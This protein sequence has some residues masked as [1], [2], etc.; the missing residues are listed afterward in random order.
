MTIGQEVV[1]ENDSMITLKDLL[2]PS[3][4]P[5]ANTIKRMFVIVKAMHE[6]AITAIRTK[7]PS[8]AA[9]VTARDNDVDRLHWLIARQTH[10]ILANAAL[11][12][13]MGITMAMAVHYFVISRIIERIGD[14]AE[15]IVDN[16]QAVLT[17]GPDP[18]IIEKIAKASELSVGIFDRSIVSF[19]NNDM[20]K[21]HKNIE[22]VQ[23][24]E[25]LCGE[26]DNLVLQQET[27]DAIALGYITESIRRAGEY[28]ADISENVINYLV[29][30]KQVQKKK[31]PAG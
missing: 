8:L 30:E 16:A 4:M 5:F 7:N 13:K 11:S 24:L 18:A 28:A 3:E 20:K 15:R 26:I 23:V 19:F 1:E 6:D 12:K 31:R 9:D 25:S 2:N 29:E 14:H 10:M 21:S 27:P 17:K 22:S